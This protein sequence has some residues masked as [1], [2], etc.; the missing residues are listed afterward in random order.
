MQPKMPSDDAPTAPPPTASTSSA[1]ASA[2]LAVV[3]KSEGAA[4]PSR[5]SSDAAMGG[6]GAV[7]SA[8]NSGDHSAAGLKAGLPLEGAGQAVSSPAELM[9]F[10]RGSP[11]LPKQKPILGLTTKLHPVS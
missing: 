10:V 9:S 6:G 2:P 8:G 3:P 4:G 11:C 7:S 5:K 1:S